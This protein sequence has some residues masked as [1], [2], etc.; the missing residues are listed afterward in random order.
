MTRLSLLLDHENLILVSD[1][2]VDPRLWPELCRTR[3]GLQVM[4]GVQTMASR[5]PWE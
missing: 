5:E 2:F 3:W 1:G 4:S